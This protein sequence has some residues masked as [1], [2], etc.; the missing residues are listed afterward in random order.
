MYLK[1]TARTALY[2]VLTTHRGIHEGTFVFQTSGQNVHV[3]CYS[4]SLIIRQ[5]T[6]SKYKVKQCIIISLVIFVLQ[7]RH[8]HK[9]STQQNDSCVCNYMLIGNTILSCTRGYIK[10]CDISIL[11]LADWLNANDMCCILVAL[12][13]HSSASRVVVTQRRRE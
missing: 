3:I 4:W 13:A 1:N 12:F 11:L 10:S 9:W 8:P 6:N 2:H 5:Q 7:K